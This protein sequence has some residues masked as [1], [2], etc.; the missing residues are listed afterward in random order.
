MK[1]ER[2]EQLQLVDEFTRLGII[3][4]FNPKQI[5]PK[6]ARKV[7]VLTSHGSADGDR[8]K[9]KKKRKKDKKKRKKDAK[10][11]KKQTG[12]DSTKGLGFD[13]LTSIINGMANSA[14]GR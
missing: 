6:K 12:F 2:Y 3:D 5:L 10:K 7:K 8:F 4:F 9:S 1:P 13:D 11:F 14:V